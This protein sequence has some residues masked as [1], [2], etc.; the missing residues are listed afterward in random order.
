MHDVDGKATTAPVT[1]ATHD[2]RDTNSER[3]GSGKDV[4]SMAVVIVTA[5]AT[6]RWQ[7]QKVTVE[8]V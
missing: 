7:R 3:D 8:L 4:T 2:L 6:D 5:A 1:T